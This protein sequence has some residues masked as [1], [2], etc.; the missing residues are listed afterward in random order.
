MLASPRLAA[1]LILVLAGSAS[2]QT[3]YPMITHV[4]PVALQRG[5]TTE[6]T[7]SGQMTFAGVY[8]AMFEGTGLSAIEMPAIPA[9]L[10]KALVKSV[11]FKVKVEQ[12]AALGVR[13]FRVASPLGASSI[14]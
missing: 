9:T 8:K 2:A 6:V 13:D 11:K 7:V 4:S 14:G 1:L 3:S 5:T 12:D 10:P